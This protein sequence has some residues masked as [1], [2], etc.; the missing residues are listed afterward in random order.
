[1]HATHEINYQSNHSNSSGAMEGARAVSMFKRTIESSKLRYISYVR[2]GDTSYAGVKAAKTY[3]E[4][5]IIECLGQ[6]QNRM[7]TRR[8]NIIG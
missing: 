3:G 4:I 7:S 6:V 2:D 5:L 1:M 8:H